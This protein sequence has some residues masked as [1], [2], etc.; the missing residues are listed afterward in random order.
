MTSI[1]FLQI[2]INTIAYATVSSYGVS[3]LLDIMLYHFCFFFA[4]N[5]FVFKYI[6]LLTWCIFCWL[7]FPALL[8]VLVYDFEDEATHLSIITL[9][10]INS[11]YYFLF[12]G[13][14]TS[15]F[16]ANFHFSLFK[17]MMLTTAI[18]LKT[19]KLFSSLHSLSIN[20]S[21]DVPIVKLSFFSFLC[22]WCSRYLK[23]VNIISNLSFIGAFVK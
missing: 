11:C 5:P 8:N 22:L 4:K 17:S 20:M 10:S 19:I 12:T 1:F 7:E 6:I 13:E 18:Q 16:L 14:C 9:I 23:I 2:Y 3:F 15:E 21:F